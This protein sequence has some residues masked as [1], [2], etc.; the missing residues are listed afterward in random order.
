[1]T[2][3]EKLYSIKNFGVWYCS[4]HDADSRF[5]EGEHKD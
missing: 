2:K 1:M 5:P 3:L 4:A